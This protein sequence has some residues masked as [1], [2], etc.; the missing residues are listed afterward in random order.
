M[1]ALPMNCNKVFVVG[2]PRS[3]TTWVRSMLA[4]HP[5]VVAPANETHVYAELYGPIVASGLDRD[6]QA[7]LLERY[8]ARPLGEDVGLQTLGTR[9]DLAAVLRAGGA[10]GR[11]SPEAAR[12]VV[13]AMLDGFANRV[14]AADGNVLV[15]KT[16]SHIFYA[17]H[18]LRHF[19]EARIV[20]VVR[21]GRDVC[22]S[23]Q[24]RATT[25]SWLPRTRAEQIRQWVGAVQFGIAV[26]STPEAVGRWHVSRFEAAR[27]DPRHAIAEL[28]TFC[29]LPFDGP[30]VDRVADA[31]DFSRVGDAGTGQFFRRGVVGDWRSDF[32][33]ADRA[34]FARL[35]GETFTAA[36]YA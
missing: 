6:A 27:D 14:G 35:A 18:I 15:E 1:C 2:C 13:A 10:S 22:V 8:D 24:H 21:D 5:L 31:T 33:D 28:F 11:P 20:E 17:H 23:M 36:G 9:D 29:G 7:A 30:L 4:A 25:V 3:G 32:D 16:P 12:Y 34:L 26:R 19:P